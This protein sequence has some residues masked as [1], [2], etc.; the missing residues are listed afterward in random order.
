[1]LLSFYSRLLNLLVFSCSSNL[2]IV[3][4]VLV[5]LLLDFGFFLFLVF[6]FPCCSPCLLLLVSSFLSCWVSFL[7]SFCLLIIT[8]RVRLNRGKKCGCGVFGAQECPQLSRRFG[9]RKFQGAWGVLAEPNIWAP[10]H[11]RRSPLHLVTLWAWWAVL[12][13][14]TF[15][16]SPVGVSSFV[17]KTT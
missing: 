13:C 12:R 5:L 8:F 16:Q 15:Y 9:R 10:V 3:G 1:M 11:G 7:F 2:W 6:S 14:T 4:G 17:R